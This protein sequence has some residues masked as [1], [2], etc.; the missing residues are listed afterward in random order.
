M[1]RRYIVTR[2]NLANRLKNNGFVC[3]E[4]DNPFREGL[5]AW[6]FDMSPQLIEDVIAFYTEID[7]CPPAYVLKVWKHMGD[8]DDE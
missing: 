8:G 5:T 4:I 6:V 3:K 7:K 2:F 1:S